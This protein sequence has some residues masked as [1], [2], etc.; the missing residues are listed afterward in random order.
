MRIRRDFPGLEL[1]IKTEPYDEK[2]SPGENLKNLA[3]A[4][5]YNIAVVTRFWGRMASDICMSEES[6]PGSSKIDLESKG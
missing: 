2:E 3:Q 6:I 4:L 1:F 5:E